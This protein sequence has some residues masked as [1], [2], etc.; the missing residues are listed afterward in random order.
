[1]REA[2]GLTQTELAELSGV[3][4]PNLAAY[5]SGARPLT[6]AMRTRLER[7]LRRP[8]ELVARHRDEIRALVAE[9]RAGDPRLFGSVARGTDRPGSDL[10]LLVSFDDSASLF[11][12]ARLHLEL[13]ALL[14]I[15]VDVLDEGGLR[16]K[17][18]GILD[19]LV[20][21]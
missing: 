4:Q 18:R 10:D 3:A 16:A 17:H 21:L 11:D 1:M 8:S 7:A 15:T 13:E 9:S 14:G 5:E 20:P 12:L 19:D 2:A 6:P